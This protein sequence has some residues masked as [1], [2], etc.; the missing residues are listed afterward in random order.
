MTGAAVNLEPRKTAIL[1]LFAMPIL[2]LFIA[3][4]DKLMGNLSMGGIKE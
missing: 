4:R 1:M 2:A 3:F